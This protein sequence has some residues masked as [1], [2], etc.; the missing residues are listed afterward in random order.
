VASYICPPS[1]S[2]SSHPTAYIH[3]LRKTQ[4]SLPC[5]PPRRRRHSFPLGPAVLRIVL[6]GM[7]CTVLLLLLLSL[8]SLA[9]A[10]WTHPPSLSFTI[11]TPSHP[12]SADSLQIQISLTN[13]G[14]TPLILLRDPRG[15]LT[16]LQ[17]HVFDI[18]KTDDGR[19]PLFTGAAV[20][21]YHVSFLFP[22]RP[23]PDRVSSQTIAYQS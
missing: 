16:Q 13:T 1:I 19:R 18:I 10:Q 23:A 11:S 3:R 4:C 8:V 20:S 6:A 17:T 21:C 15:P 22:Q 7:R 14:H 12:V 2:P 9:L 5:S